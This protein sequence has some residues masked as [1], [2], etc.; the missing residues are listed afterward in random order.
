VRSRVERSCGQTDRGFTLIELLVSIT[1]MSLV[2]VAIHSG[3]RLSLNSWEKSEKALQRHRTLQFVL[4]LIT[5]QVGSMVPFYSRQQLDGVPV[6]VLLF[7]DSAQGVR[8]VSSF[9]AEARAADGLRLVEYFLTDSPTG[10]G[11]VLMMNETALPQNSELVG[12]VFSSFSRGE[13]NYVVPTFRS[14]AAT[15]DSVVLAQDLIEAHFE[16]TRKAKDEDVPAAGASNVLLPGRQGELM[17]FFNRK[18]RASNKRNQLPLGLRLKLGWKETGYFQ[19]Q[20]FSIVV[21]IQAGV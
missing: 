21:P 3:F 18:G 17:A 6:D 13:D 14:F 12:R 8:F 19:M 1:L 5:R 4:D 15:S 2:M 16:Y 7:Q 20:E 11:K 10:E 9:S